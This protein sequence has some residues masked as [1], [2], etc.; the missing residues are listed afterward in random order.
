MD[1][2]FTCWKILLLFGYHS[3]FVFLGKVDKYTSD[4]QSPSTH[5]REFA[6]SGYVSRV[7]H[8][9]HSWKFIVIV[10]NAFS[11]IFSIFISFGWRSWYICAIISIFFSLVIH[12]W[13]M[14]S[15]QTFNE[16]A[17]VKFRFFVVFRRIEKCKKRNI[18]ERTESFNEFASDFLVRSH[19]FYG[20]RFLLFSLPVVCIHPYGIHQLNRNMGTK[21]DSLVSWFRQKTKW[22]IYPTKLMELIFLRWKIDAQHTEWQSVKKHGSWCSLRRSF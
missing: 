1:S 12:I 4:T 2:H 11:G 9:N 15:L 13:L 16:M 19:K 5:C 10:S 3:S 20:R 8:E 6:L 21:H 18:H 7:W 17:F 22:E 14:P